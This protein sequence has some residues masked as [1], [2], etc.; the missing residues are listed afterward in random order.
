MKNV[1]I[2]KE[3]DKMIIEVDLTKEHGLSSSGKNT[4]VA[5]TQGNVAFENV[6]VGLNVYK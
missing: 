4:V 6:K 1:V 3:G 2:R 5:T